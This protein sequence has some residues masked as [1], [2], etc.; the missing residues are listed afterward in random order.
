MVQL[1][2]LFLIGAI[3]LLPFVESQ[4]RTI[5]KREKSEADK[6]LERKAVLKA[7]GS[8]IR[9]RR[10]KGK[11]VEFDP[12]GQSPEDYDEFRH[13]RFNRFHDVLLKMCPLPLK[14]RIAPR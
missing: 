6:D 14:C 7:L 13:A 8:I 3:F 11:G 2:W 5:K 9:E 1:G 4:Y 10:R 12:E